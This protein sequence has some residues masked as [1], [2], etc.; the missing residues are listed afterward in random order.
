MATDDTDTK[1][2]DLDDTPEMRRL[3]KAVSNLSPEKKRELLERWFRED[4][5]PSDPTNPPEGDEPE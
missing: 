3:L 1:H 4:L 5:S 2:S